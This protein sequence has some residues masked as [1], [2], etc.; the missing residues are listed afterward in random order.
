V[1]LGG[2]DEVVRRE[3]RLVFGEVAELYDRHRPAYPD[4]VIDDLVELAGLEADALV[5]EVGAGTGKATAM[6]AAR[7]VRV[8]AVEPSAEMAAVARRVCAAYRDVRIEQADFERWDA[9]GREF[10][11][12]FAAQAWHWVQ[13]AVGFAKAASVLRP[14]GVLAAFWN[15]A[16]W[17]RASL[18]EVV[19]GAY[20]QAAPEILAET[21]PIHPGASSLPTD[22]EDWRRGIAAA[23]GLGAVDVRDYEWSLM[24]SGADYAAL[25]ET[26]STV[27]ALEP[28]RRSA[29]VGAVARAIESHGDELT[30]PLLTRLCLARRIATP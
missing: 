10:P 30:L 13:P 28:D 20:R 7:G 16:V 2:R 29:L 4:A 11:L 8:L 3:Q 26:H 22:D 21:D 5:L 9:A 24:F 23:S 1:R 15:R 14:G 17:A 25:L 12:V 18:R 27:R 6:F 19:L